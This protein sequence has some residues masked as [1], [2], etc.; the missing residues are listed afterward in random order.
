MSSSGNL[1]H[2]I[3]K[4]VKDI[5]PA[6]RSIAEAILSNPT[7]VQTLSISELAQLAGV[8][9]STVSRFLR[10]F[11]L[12]GYKSLRLGIA[13][14]VYAQ[15]RVSSGEETNYVYEGILRTDSAGLVLEKV[16]Q[17]SNEALARTA[18]SLDSEVLQ[19]V[20]TE[21]ES[22]ES[23][24]FV[25]MGSSTIAA[26][27]AIMRFVR[28][29][30]KCFI[31]RDQSVQVM[32]S[33]TLSARD[34]VVAISDS[35]Q[36]L[37]IVNAARVAALH[38]SKVVAITS[39]A[40]SPLADAADYLFLTQ[41][42]SA[43]SDVYGETVTSKW[44]QLFAIDALYAIFAVKNFEETSGYLQETYLSGIMGTRSGNFSK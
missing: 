41:S 29:G 36:S 20:V 33:A 39:S 12:D 40:V 22:A 7:H 11:D 15:G 4:R 5:S 37:P 13:Q 42:T 31:Y 24:Y 2:L 43:S 34:L 35:G 44:G 9:D 25:A 3:S 27:N 30:K 28:A 10:E 14:A 17:A 6:L 23:I 32:A 38:G 8:A 18:A 16:L 21:I 19:A 1:L 26:E